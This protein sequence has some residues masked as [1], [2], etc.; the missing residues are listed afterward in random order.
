AA[1]SLVA[2]S[3]RAGQRGKALSILS[4]AT[5]LGGATS[6]VMGGALLTIWNGTDLITLPL[7]GHLEMWRAVFLVTGLPGFVVALLMLALREPGRIIPAAG[8]AQLSDFAGHVRRNWRLFLPLYMSFSAVFFFTYGAVLW[9]PTVLSRIYGFA[10][11][12]AGMAS[13]TFQMG[14]SIFGTIIAGV[15]G[16]FLITRNAKHGRLRIWLI[17][18]IPVLIAAMLLAL[19]GAKFYLIGFALTMFTT[20]LLIGVSY[21][22][23]YDAVEPSMRGRALALYLF[24]ANVC[25]IGGGSSGVALITD[26]VLKDEKLLNYSVAIAVLGAALFSGLMAI[27]ALRR[28]EAVRLDLQQQNAS[29]VIMP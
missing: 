5:G 23:L 29:A 20:S 6:K 9:S 10:P 17:G 16:D 28:Y 21:P 18:L 2:D 13:G 12:T 15:V 11:G 1:Y 25:G 27:L 14:G 22:A 19:P 7:V 8:Q 24:L 4:V 26:H 3:F